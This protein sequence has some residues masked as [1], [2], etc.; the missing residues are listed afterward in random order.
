MREVGVISLRKAVSEEPH[1]RVLTT[2]SRAYVSSPL[3]DRWKAAQ[4]AC[5][6][7]SCPSRCRSTQARRQ[8][9]V[10]RISQ[11]PDGRS[12][13]AFATDPQGSIKLVACPSNDRFMTP[14]SRSSPQTQR[15]PLGPIP[16]VCWPRGVPSVRFRSLT[17]SLPDEPRSQAGQ[18]PL[19][20]IW[21]DQRKFV[22]RHSQFS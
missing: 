21:H 13:L 17:I 22:G 14:S 16:T 20:Q 9:H 7:G 18:R 5:R 11:P 12:A 10:E 2:L 19:A 6:H 15:S 4:I 3:G 8:T 1:L